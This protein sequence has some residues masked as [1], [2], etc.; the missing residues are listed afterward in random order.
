MLDSHVQVSA[1]LTHTRSTFLQSWLCVSPWG[2]FCSS[3]GWLCILTSSC[4]PWNSS[5]A[6][7]QDAWRAVFRALVW[8]AFAVPLHRVVGV[9]LIAKTFPQ[10]FISSLHSHVLWCW[11]AVREVRIWHSFRSCPQLWVN[12]EV[13][14]GFLVVS[15][16]T[17][18]TWVCRVGSGRL[19]RPS[20]LPTVPF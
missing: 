12:S 11:V 16:F 14:Q 19:G 4:P 5:Q 10:S 18:I 2:L 1:L 3:L 9:I 20:S 8:N 6:L 15:V 17:F 13:P 7:K